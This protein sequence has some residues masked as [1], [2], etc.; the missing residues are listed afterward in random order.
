[1]TRLTRRRC[2]APEPRLP[3]PLRLDAVD[4]PCF[5]RDDQDRPSDATDRLSRH[6]G[7]YAQLGIRMAQEETNTAGGVTG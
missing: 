6:P 4:Q 3:T 1:M 2:C 7:S 5:A